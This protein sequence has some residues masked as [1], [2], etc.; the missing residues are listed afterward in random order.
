[1]RRVASLVVL[2]VACSSD[3]APPP[4]N[5]GPVARFKLSDAPDFM[6]VPF[7][8]DVYLQGGTVKVPG[9]DRVFKVGSSYLSHELERMDGFSRVALAMFYVDDPGA[10]LDDDGEVAFAPIDRSTLPVDEKACVA[11]ESSVF[12]LDLQEGT[13]VPCRADFHDDSQKSRG[14]PNVAVGP[15]RGIVLEEGRR[16]AAV[17]TDRVR[18]TQGRA[19]RASEDLAKVSGMYKEALDKARA[20]LPG[21]ANIVAI[22][23]FTTHTR[24]REML[25]IKATLDAQPAPVL[26]WDQASVSPMKAAR[27]GRAPLP[28]DF[29]ATLDDWLGVATEK[30]PDG[31]DDPDAALPVRAHDKIAAVGTAVFE[32][33]SFLQKKP[34]GYPELDHAT[35][36]RDAAGKVVPTGTEKIWVTI[37]I[38]TAAMPA[39]GYPVVI[40][41][42]GLGGSRSYLLELANTICARGWIAVAIDSVTFGARAPGAEFQRDEHSDYETRGATYKGGDGLADPDRFGNRN[43]N[44]DLFGSLKNI[45]AL[46]DQFRQA[47]LDTT[48]LVR[49]LRDPSLDLSPL[50]A[51]AKIDPAR[52]AYLGDSLGSIQGAVAATLEPNVKHWVLNVAG[53]GLLTELASRGPAIGAILQLAAGA[54]F[55]FLRVNLNESHPM[56]VVLQNIVDPADPIIYAPHLIRKPLAGGPKNILQFEVLYD[57]LVSNEANESL[58]RAAGIGL[59]LPNAGSNA[60]ISNLKDLSANPWRVP[61][62][63]VA[64]DDQQEIHDTPVPGVTAVVVQVSPAQH[65]SNLVRSTGERQFAIPYAQFDKEPANVH[66][67]VGKYITVRCPYRELQ[68]M[69]TRFLE[70]GFAGRVPRVS[71]I[72]PPVRDADDDGI[73]DDKDP[74]PINPQI[75]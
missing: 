7:P 57:E 70:D 2:A 31:T 1:M 24:V 33:T 14:R 26:K 8:S 48:Q 72:K 40:I 64:P 19:V 13:R 68:A 41:Q 71:G 47:E 73:T 58:A 5:S 10:P 44:T 65:G 60:G 30:L 55:G 28:A 42:H 49:L 18:D 16:Y 53:G 69:L 50:Q 61:L 23:P 25:E 27:F 6:E 66:L 12:V 45:G 3:P 17:M 32:A 63:D 52:V 15:A 20:L 46:R 74:D 59:A 35:F 43:G 29:T 21:G 67:D 9:L 36:A 39:D 34:G 51:G 22:A 62:P 56:N 38:P 75:K 4:T 11:D 37:A 54:N